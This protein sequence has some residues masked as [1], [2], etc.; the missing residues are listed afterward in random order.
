MSLLDFVLSNQANSAARFGTQAILG[1]K[2]AWRKVVGIS[3]CMNES[4]GPEEKG[5]ML[6]TEMLEYLK[7]S[8]A[9][10]VF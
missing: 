1:E 6:C 9:V 8:I 3:S 2:R 4:K 10:F 7:T 5:R